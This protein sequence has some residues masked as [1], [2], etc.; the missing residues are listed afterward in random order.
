MSQAVEHQID[1]LSKTLA[2]MEAALDRIEAKL[3]SGPGEESSSVFVQEWDNLIASFFKPFLNNSEK[4]GGDVSNQAHIFEQAVNANREILVF[5]SNNTKPDDAKFGEVL[6][7]LSQKMRAIKEFEEK[8]RKTKFPNHLKTLGEG[9]GVFGW[10]AQALPAPY[11]GEIKSSSEF[12]SNKILTEFKGKDQNQIEW[13][14]SFGSFLKEL[15]AY[16]K[17][18]HT[19]GL[20]WKK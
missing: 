4:I 1:E 7:P 12:W 3:N 14:Q 19:Q 10:V 6:A 8:A 18:Y 16:T 17:Q 9:A 13:V 5:A 11:V 2:R 20:S 15:Q